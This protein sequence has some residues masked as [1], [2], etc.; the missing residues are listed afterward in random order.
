MPS[1]INGNIY[2]TAN[3]WRKKFINGWKYGCKLSSDT[4]SSQ[5]PSKAK[6][7]LGWRN[8]RKNNS[9]QIDEKG[10]LYYDNFTM[11]TIFLP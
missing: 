3:V 6:K 5:K 8:N 7:L 2:P 1:P 9:D 10:H 4:Y 11:K